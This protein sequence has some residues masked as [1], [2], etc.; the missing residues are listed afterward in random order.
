[1]TLFWPT[2]YQAS[3][4]RTE[5]KKEAHYSSELV[6]NPRTPIGAVVLSALVD[7]DKPLNTFLT[8]TVGYLHRL[9]YVG[10][11][12]FREKA[13]FRFYIFSLIIAISL[14]SNIDM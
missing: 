7:G 12:I 2:M 10:I 4:L 6:S 14:N 5:W 1:M 8:R 11:T 3:G 9:L 13:H